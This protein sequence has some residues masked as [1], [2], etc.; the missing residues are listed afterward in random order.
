MFIQKSKTF[1][2]QVDSS[3]LLISSRKCSRILI[4]CVF[5]NAPSKKL[6]IKEGIIFCRIVE[7]IEAVENTLLGNED[8]L[9]DL[10]S[11][12][13]RVDFA[14]LPRIWDTLGTR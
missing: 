14:V 4:I 9:S 2:S 12:R 7:R 5:T 11:F 1:A 6:T 10:P 8:C 3:S 13:S